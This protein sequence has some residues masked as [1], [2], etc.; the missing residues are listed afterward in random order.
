MS[1][2]TIV[3]NMRS[4][5]DELDRVY[6]GIENPV[7]GLSFWVLV[8]FFFFLYATLDMT[9]VCVGLCVIVCAHCR[10]KLLYGRR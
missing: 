4:F 8:V 1:M 2:D 7:R 9:C 5:L 6:K 10:G 3:Y